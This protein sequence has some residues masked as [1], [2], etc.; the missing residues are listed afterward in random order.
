VKPIIKFLVI[1]TGYTT[2]K[3]A[4]PWGVGKNVWDWDGKI[5]QVAVSKVFMGK[6][7]H[8][9]TSKKKRPKGA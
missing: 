4:A 8:S 7:N 3:T 2:T 1:I 9:L 6:D 5:E